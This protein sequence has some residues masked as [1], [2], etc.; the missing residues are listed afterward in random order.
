MMHTY[1]LRDTK[2][3]SG[4]VCLAIPSTLS[5]CCII[6]VDTSETTPVLILRLFSRFQ[7]CA[8][9]FTT[10]FSSIFFINWTIMQHPQLGCSLTRGTFCRSHCKT[11]CIFNDVRTYKKSQTHQETAKPSHTQIFVFCNMSLL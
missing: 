3:S 8:H 10:N 6:P 9:L 4:N 2:I 5:Y 1:M 11:L 7:Q